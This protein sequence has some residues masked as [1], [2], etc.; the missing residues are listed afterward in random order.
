MGEETFEALALEKS[1]V[2][3]YPHLGIKTT[4][5]AKGAHHQVQRALGS[6]RLDFLVVQRMTALYWAKRGIRRIMRSLEQYC[7]RINPLA[8]FQL[9]FVDISDPCLSSL[10]PRM[11][12]NA[13]K[14]QLVLNLP[15]SFPVFPTMRQYFP[16]QENPST[17]SF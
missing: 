16:P 5:P 11:T 1:Y 10:L 13:V 7:S 15:L 4:S 3:C 17:P 6:R 2:N 9:Y 14:P 8:T 12:C